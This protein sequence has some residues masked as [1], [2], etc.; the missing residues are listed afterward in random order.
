MTEQHS[1]ITERFPEL[2]GLDC[3]DDDQRLETY[4]H[5]LDALQRE[6]EDDRD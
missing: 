1:P 5:V 3:Q 4:R 2:A 6:L